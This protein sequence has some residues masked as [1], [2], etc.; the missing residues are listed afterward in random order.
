MLIKC[1]AEVYLKQFYREL[2]QRVRGGMLE[3]FLLPG[4]GED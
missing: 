3:I 1:Y 4:V 2:M